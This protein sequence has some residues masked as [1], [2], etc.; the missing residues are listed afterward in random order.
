MNNPLWALAGVAL[1]GIAGVTGVVIVAS[2]SGEE[3][4]VQGLETASPSASAAPSPVPSASSTA[5][6]S[7]TPPPRTPGEGETLWRWA[8]VTIV[9]PDDSQISVGRGGSLIELGLGDTSY[10]AINGSDGVVLDDRVQPSDR[11]A[12]DEVLK[13]IA[14]ASLDPATA[15]WPYN[16]EP[17]PAL[18]KD[19]AGN[20]I[21]LHPDPAAGIAV[22]FGISEGGIG[23]F[24]E[25]SNGRSLMFIQAKTGELLGG[26]RL[27][28]QDEA[29][30]EKYL[31][32]IVTCTDTTKC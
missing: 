30:F 16:G 4:A 6:S 15:P 20:L 25:V 22:T 10:L 31:N 9:V 3:E 26:Q 23:E 8:N 11:A 13:T 7:S 28:P 17:P 24:I 27:E 1:V 2:Q 19:R 32:S 12:F 5:T 21:Y 14:V 29:V 18:Q